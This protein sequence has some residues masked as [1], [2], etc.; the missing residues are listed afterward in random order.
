MIVLLSMPA[1][2]MLTI[3]KILMEVILFVIIVVFHSYTEM[4]F[5]LRVSK[6]CSGKKYFILLY[7]SNFGMYLMKKAYI[8]INACCLIIYVYWHN[9]IHVCSIQN[10]YEKRNFVWREFNITKKKKHLTFF[11]LWYTIQIIR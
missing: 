7:I 11:C 5:F 8:G 6:L 9:E 10:R 2:I 3:T 4:D 1:A